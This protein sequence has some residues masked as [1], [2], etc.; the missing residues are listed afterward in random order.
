MS[1]RPTGGGPPSTRVNAIILAL[2]AKYI[3][4]CTHSDSKTAATLRAVIESA[5]VDNPTRS[6]VGL[7]AM[8]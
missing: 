1:Q 3:A 5:T 8:S 2:Q 6:A 4:Q 7:F